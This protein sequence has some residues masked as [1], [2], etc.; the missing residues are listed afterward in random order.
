MSIQ[1]SNKGL[2]PLHVTMSCGPLT[3]TIPRCSSYNPLSH[4]SPGQRRCPLTPTQSVPLASAEQRV[5]PTDSSGHLIQAKKNPFPQ[6]IYE[7]APFFCLALETVNGKMSLP[8]HSEQIHSLFLLRGKYCTHA[9]LLPLSELPT[10]TWQYPSRPLAA[11][12]KHIHYI[13][14]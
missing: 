11:P 4:T 2:S 7:I 6:I 13:V 3:P 1:E 5:R 9:P 14:T 8:L 10:L 12:L